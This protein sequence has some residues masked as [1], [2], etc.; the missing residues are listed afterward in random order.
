MIN[1]DYAFFVVFGF[2]IVSI[3]YLLIRE[4][5]NKDKDMYY[6]CKK[7]NMGLIESL[8]KQ[9]KELNELLQHNKLKR[10]ESKESDKQK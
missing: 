5:H 9:E 4:M 8:K 6:D 3:L 2:L 7:S 10:T 1:N